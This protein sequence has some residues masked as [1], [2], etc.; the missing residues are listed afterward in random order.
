MPVSEGETFRTMV[1]RVSPEDIVLYANLALASYL[2]VPK[3][4]LIGAPLE[5]LATRAQGEV[6]A[7]FQRPEGGRASNRLV[8]DAEGRVFEVK[9]YSE[10]GI[11]DIVMDEVTTVDSVSRDLRHVSGTSVDLLNEEELRTARQPERRYLTVSRVRLNGISHLADLLA[12]M[13]MRL[14]LNSFVEESADAIMET[15]CTY[16]E[17]SGGSVTGI[18]GAPRYFADHALRAVRAACIQMEKF[19]QLRAGLFR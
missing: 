18:F 12:P 6:M 9:T 11:L 10:G 13:E 2:R 7:C 17:S 14:M 8:T 16:F 3:S 1:V 4:D 15:G 19:A 5:I